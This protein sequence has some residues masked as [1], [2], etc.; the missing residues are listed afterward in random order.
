MKIPF[1]KVTARVSHGKKS[2][3]I[4]ENGHKIV[5]K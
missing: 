1:L 4:S 2:V 5:Q 3:K